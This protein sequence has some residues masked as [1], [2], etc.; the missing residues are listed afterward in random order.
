MYKGSHARRIALISFAAFLF[1]TMKAIIKIAT[2]GKFTADQE[3]II[4]RVAMVLSEH[5]ISVSVERKIKKVQT[6]KLK[7][8]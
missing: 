7:A 4:R 3:Q 8:V 2:A 1:T 6:F 5:S